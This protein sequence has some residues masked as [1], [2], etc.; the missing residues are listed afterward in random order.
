VSVVI[1]ER[2][3]AFAQAALEW[4][5]GVVD[6]PPDKED[7]EAVLPPDVC[8]LLKCPE[9]VTLSHQI[10]DG[11]MAVNLASDF[12]ERMEVLFEA[13]PFI[14]VFKIPGLYLKQSSME[15]PVARAFT[16]RN[17]KVKVLSAQPTQLEYQTWHFFVSLHSEDRWEDTCSVTINPATRVEIQMPDPATI[18]SLTPNHE[19]QAN[20]LDT[21]DLAVRLM[22]AKVKSRAANFIERI[23]SKLKR[24]HKRLHDYYNALLE[25][26]DR[27]VAAS[28]SETTDVKRRELAEAV[29]LELRRKSMEMDERY[30]VKAEFK[31]LALLRAQ[32]P[33]LEV[34]L[35]VFRKQSRRIHTVYWNPLMK[36]L[37][38]LGCASCGAG[39]NSVF[40]SDKEVDPLCPSCAERRGLGARR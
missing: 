18:A 27:K 32:I 6:W 15:E 19:P 3:S 12:L 13:E 4:R 21:F 9:A 38:P 33:A 24:D 14:G 36:Q 16:W 23:D 40:F 7:G 31:P 37:E 11:V 29:Q 30:A 1:R 5:G 39:V 22:V 28:K 34:K 8:L 25:E 17:A 26:T 2:L 20:H 35:E 10:R